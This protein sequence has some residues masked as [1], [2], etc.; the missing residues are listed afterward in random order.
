[1]SS[2]ASPTTT[3][4][5]AAIFWNRCSRWSWVRRAS[6]DGKVMDARKSPQLSL[7]TEPERQGNPAHP[8]RVAHP[9]HMTRVVNEVDAAVPREPPV[10]VLPRGAEREACRALDDTREQRGSR[11][12]RRDGRIRFPEVAFALA[13]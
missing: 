1:M 7:C 8:P 9:A 5:R 2:I 12:V 6:E 4:R 13:Q 10:S 3:T 11:A